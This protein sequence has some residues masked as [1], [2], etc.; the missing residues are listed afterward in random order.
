MVHD[1]SPV[2]RRRKRDCRRTTA[3]RSIDGQP[4]HSVTCRDGV[5]AA[6]GGKPV[7][8]EIERDGQPHAACT[9]PM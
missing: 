2:I 4:V 7:N 5:S 8:L 1:V 6:A 3:L 9:T